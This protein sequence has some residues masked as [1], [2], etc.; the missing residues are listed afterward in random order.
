MPSAVKRIVTSIAAQFDWVIKH[1]ENHEAVIESSLKDLE[2]ATKQ[3]IIKL[4]AVQ[5]DGMRL[6][7]EIGKLAEQQELW[8][9]RA[10]QSEDDDKARECVKRIAWGEETER[11]AHCQQGYPSKNYCTS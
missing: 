2:R 3:A 1:V 8:A 5:K 6:D 11:K 9:A 10:T 4:R 7:E